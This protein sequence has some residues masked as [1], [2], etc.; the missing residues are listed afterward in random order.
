MTETL[1]RDLRPAGSKESIRVFDDSVRKVFTANK[2]GAVW[3][4]GYS[5]PD[6]AYWNGVKHYGSGPS[7]RVRIR[8]TPAAAVKLPKTGK[9]MRSP[10]LDT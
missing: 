1:S 10:L 5:Q 7:S 2:D 8:R 9:R 3:V 6:S 4:F